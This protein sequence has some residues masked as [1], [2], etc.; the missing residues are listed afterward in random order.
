MDE[1]AL[2][3]D[4]RSPVVQRDDDFQEDDPCERCEAK[5]LSV[6]CGANITNGL[7]HCC[8]DHAIS[9]CEKCEDK[10]KS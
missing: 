6:C 5:D 10:P 4:P 3:H 8:H 2:L 9:F 1:Y 7:C